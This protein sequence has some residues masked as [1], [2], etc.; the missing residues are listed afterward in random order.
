[1]NR[2]ANRDCVMRRPREKWTE[3]LTLP[4]RW[5][6]RQSN[7]ERGRRGEGEINRITQLSRSLGTH[8]AAGSR[9]LGVAAM[10]AE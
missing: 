4:E 8:L 6:K 10:V 3:T 9:C 1:M 7:G 5:T 2:G